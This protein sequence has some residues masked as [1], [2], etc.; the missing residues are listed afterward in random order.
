MKTKNKKVKKNRV[1][2]TGWFEVDKPMPIPDA[3]FKTLREGLEA[4]LRVQKSTLED[5]EEATHALMTQKNGNVAVQLYG[6][7]DE[8][9][10]EAVEK[11]LKKQ[12]NSLCPEATFHTCHVNTTMLNEDGSTGEKGEAI[13]CVARSAYEIRMVIQPYTRNDDGSIIWGERIEHEGIDMV[14]SHL[15]GCVYQKE[16]TYIK[17]PPKTF[18][19]YLSRGLETLV[20]AYNNPSSIIAS[21]HSPNMKGISKDEQADSIGRAADLITRYETAGSAADE[22]ILLLMS[23]EAEM[24]RLKEV[25]KSEWAYITQDGKDLNYALPRMGADATEKFYRLANQFGIDWMM[26]K[27]S[28]WHKNGL[29]MWAAAA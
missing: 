13:V 17:H 5:G 27:A 9:G 4:N 20:D 19:E 18:S 25:N 24:K 23:V 29:V 14:D 2:K 22:A 8:R 26:E 3:L 7:E 11:K 6:F 16:N 28:E 12:V 1:K 21:R 15:E 10:K